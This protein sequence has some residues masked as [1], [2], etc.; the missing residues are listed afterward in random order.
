MQTMKIG[1]VA[2]SEYVER[3]KGEQGIRVV[4]AIVSEDMIAA[5]THYDDTFG[6]N[7]FHCFKG[8]CCR[9]FNVPQQRYVF[10]VLVYTGDPKN[11]GEP[12]ELKFLGLT[13][14]QYTGE[15]KDLLDTMK[16]RNEDI[17]NRDLLL[18]CK[19]TEYQQN[20]FQ[21]LG[22]AKWKS[23]EKIAVMV[24]EGL[25]RYNS[26]IG[27]SLGRS[28]EAKELMAIISK[29]AAGSDAAAAAESGNRLDAA[30]P[31]AETQELSKADVGTLPF[32]DK[33]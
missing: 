33:K 6:L 9:V 7:Y 31:A 18:S 19:N 17:T 2:P 5:S 10:P 22:E 1:Q 32:P 29:S 11:Y 24:K 21:A 3:L 30:Q 26:I 4:Y 8:E 12:V 23:N 20:S 27:R 28:I 25:I 15:F 14:K 16:L 13:R